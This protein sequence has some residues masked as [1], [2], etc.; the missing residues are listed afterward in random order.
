MVNRKNKKFNASLR[1][2]RTKNA[3]FAVFLDLS[4][5]KITKIHFLFPEFSHR[6]TLSGVI[7]EKNITHVAR[8][9][10]FPFF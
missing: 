3:N 4:T 8:L 10:A 7:Q 5:Q 2:Y 9:E 6:S 1:F